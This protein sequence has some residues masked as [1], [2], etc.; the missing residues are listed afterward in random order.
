MEHNKQIQSTQVGN[1]DIIDEYF[2]ELFPSLKPMELPK[3]TIK[4]KRKVH[5]S[6]L[7]YQ[8]QKNK[9]FEENDY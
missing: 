5:E 3:K 8:K 2:Y 4:F 1:D 7:R 6:I 9:L